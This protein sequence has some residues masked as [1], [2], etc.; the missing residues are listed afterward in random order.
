MKCFDCEYHTRWTPN[1]GDTV[2]IQ[3][4]IN[5][6]KLKGIRLSSYSKS[7]DYFLKLTSM[8]SWPSTG[9]YHELP[10]LLE[11]D[12]QFSRK[13]QD[14]GRGKAAESWTDRLHKLDEARTALHQYGDSPSLVTLIALEKALAPLGYSFP[15]Q[16]KNREKH[17]YEEVGLEPHGSLSIFCTLEVL[18]EFVLQYC[19]DRLWGL[20]LVKGKN[21]CT[22]KDVEAFPWFHKKLGELRGYKIVLTSKGPHF[23]SRKFDPDVKVKVGPNGE[24]AIDCMIKLYT[25]L[26]S[27]D[28]CPISD[29]K[30]HCECEENM[31]IMEPLVSEMEATKRW[32]VPLVDS[33][34]IGQLAT[35]EE[36]RVSPFREKL[37]VPENLI[38]ITE[39]GRE[40]LNTPDSI[41]RFASELPNLWN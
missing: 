8:F 37:Y 2:L 27:D 30:A 39:R 12:E 29:L 23:F 35:I 18:S 15:W 31:Q 5:W 20:V 22:V 3:Y 41:A 17:F 26:T 38:R 19:Q 7:C 36:K 11:K 9:T 34:M 4:V 13:M 10:K 40:I 14:K 32:Y 1:S 28:G 24:Q 16:D 6:C 21:N 25:L 33:L